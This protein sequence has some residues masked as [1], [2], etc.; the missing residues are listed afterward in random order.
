MKFSIFSLMQ[1]PAN[2]SQTSSFKNE[3]DQLTLAE[4]Q[5]YF[6]AWLGEDPFSFGGIGPAVHLTAASLAARTSTIRIG[7]ATTILPFMHPLRVAEEVAML[8]ILSEGRIDWGIGRGGSGRGISGDG[9]DASQSPKVFY[10]QLEVIRLAWAGKPFSYQGVFYNFDEL[11]CYPSP[12]Q[13]PAP[14]TYITALG[15]STVE[16]AAQNGY[17]VLGDPYSTFARL[18]EN[19]QR[20]L[21]IAAKASP[22]VDVGENESPTLRHVY[23]GETMQNARDDVT[24]GLLSYYRS[25][26]NAGSA[27]N[28]AEAPL[29][30][31]DP[32]N[33]PEGFLKSLF[34]DCTI[35]GD[36]AFC[37]DRV[38]QLNE[39]IGLDHII[40]WQNFA[41]L[42]AE[43]SL[44]SQ[45]RLIEEVAPAF[46]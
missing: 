18:A 29:S 6:S 15:S 11:Q 20:Y 21:D 46:A 34:D 40:C 28:R 5:G 10:E 7:T 42:D 44:A 31:N 32:D 35:I 37:R 45:K 14:K 1:W 38:A 39:E 19:R 9:S 17:P 27:T 41:G 25:I 12:V 22:E 16:W 8:D 3:I 23:V 30:D 2:R 26:E 4:S 33:D 43:Q 36:A 24:P 13:K